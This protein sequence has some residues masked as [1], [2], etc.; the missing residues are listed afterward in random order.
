M[1]TCE[2]THLARVEIDAARAAAQHL[3]YERA[4]TRLGCVVQRLGAGPEMP[5]SVFIEDTAVVLDEAA[6]AMRP[7]AESRR[8]EVPAVAEALAAHR[9][10]ARI[11]PPGTMDGGDVMVAGRM[12]FVGASS[13]T[14]YAGIEQLRRIV[15]PLGYEVRSV[16]V[17]GCLHLKSAVTVVDDETLLIN[18]AWAPAGDFGGFDL[19]NVDSGEPFGANVVRVRNRLLYSVAFPRTRERLERRGFD[20]TAIDVSELAKAEG[21]LTCCSLIVNR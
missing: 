20:V 2:L 3:E 18:Q 14:N 15:A 6:V 17:T 8:A 12:I 19:L 4:L 21:A 7:G 11:D 13:R 1:A 10:L 5:D 9:R 16:V